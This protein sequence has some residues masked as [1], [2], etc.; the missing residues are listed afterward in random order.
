MVVPENTTRS[1]GWTGQLLER[2]L[3]ATAGSKPVPDF[4]AIGVEMKSLPVDRT[5]MPLESTYICKVAHM[6]TGAT[7]WRESWA[8]HKL[9][10]VLWVPVLGERQIPISERIIGTPFLWTPSQ[11]EESILE[12]DWKLLQEWILQGG[13]GEITGTMGAAL[14]IRPKAGSSAEKKWMLGEDGEWIKETPRGYYLRTSFTHRVLASR[15]ALPN[16][17]PPP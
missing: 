5:G 16:R 15:L 14:H 10:R 11:R 9:A 3:G 12:A 2:V 13:I 6:E 1:K 8:C 4:E 7:P 17:P